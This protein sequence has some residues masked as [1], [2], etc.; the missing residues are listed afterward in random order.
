M[1]TA[2]T[3]ED[4]S[5]K[6]GR[7]G[8]LGIV[9]FVVAASAPLVGMTGAVPVA[10]LAGNG[11]A[12]PGAYL[13]VGI[14]LL[15]FSVG[16][17][18]MAHKVTNTGAFFAYV[19]RGLGIKAGVA[20]AFISIVGYV[21]IQL[22]IY[23]FFGAI[24]S[25]QMATLGLELPWYVWSILAWALV[26]ALSLLSVDVGAK[27]LGTLMIL[28][29]LSLIITAIAILANGGPEGWNIGAS[30]A[31]D[32][33][34]AGGFGGG[35]GIAIA[36]AFASFIGFEATA[37]YGEESVD[38][39]KTVR[40][41]TYWAIGIITAL[42][43]VVSFAMVTGMGANAIFDQVIERSS[44]EG[45]PLAD[46]AAVLFSLTDQY[47]GGWM[48]TIMSWLVVSSLFAGLL[49]FQNATAR[50][51]FAMG[52]GGILSERFA[53][54]NKAGAPRAGVILTSIIALVVI[55]I[56]AV[57]QLDPVLNLFFWMSAITAISI[58]LVEILV[59][60]AVIAYF[61]KNSGANAWQGKI[62]PALAA[63]GLVLGEYLLMSRFNLLAGTV[64]D[65][66]DPSLPESA[67]AL[68]PLGWF[69]VLLPFIAGIIGFIVAAV[70]G[71]EKAALTEDILS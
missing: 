39:K 61:A 34:F 37:I 22:A 60:V 62:A 46:P 70:Q 16:Y 5:L 4:T 52:R 53:H 71:K 64:A 63:I 12:A 27:V 23:G 6:K 32:Q 51:F 45:V 40:R 59:S 57:A 14:V 13:A 21:T 42:F 49:A 18:A 1:S 28:E 38:P 56:F 58:I 48:V 31:P 69:L 3:A 30:F 8:V 54:V 55:V 44:I 67:W 7:L 17:T 66:V 41:A 15:L 68:S 47:V 43:A 10:M 2:Q 19:G 11:A 35:A 9:F 20:S 33:I 24:L 26:T 65:G 50:Y 36:F 25:G 29:L